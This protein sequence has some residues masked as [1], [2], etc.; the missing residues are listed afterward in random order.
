MA[1]IIENM[2]GRRLVRVSVDDIISMVRV[3]QELVL[4]SSS[5]DDLRVKLSEADIYLPEDF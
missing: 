3:Y 4:K 1:Q 5:Y 2:H